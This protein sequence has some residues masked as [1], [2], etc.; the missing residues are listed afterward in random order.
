MKSGFI[1]EKRVSDLTRRFDGV[2][3]SVIFIKMFSQNLIR[4]TI[5]EDFGASIKPGTR[6][7]PEHPG[8][9]RNIPENEKIK[10]ICIKKIIII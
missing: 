3:F 10:I 8:T 1:Y 5:P 2:T 6:N 7:I 4:I 9:S